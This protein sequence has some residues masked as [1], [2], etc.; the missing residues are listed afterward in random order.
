MRS[1]KCKMINLNVIS[2]LRAMVCSLQSKSTV[3]GI[4]DVKSLILSAKRVVS[5]I[6]D[7]RC[8]VW[9][10]IRKN[11]NWNL[12]W[13]TQRTYYR[14]L[15]CTSFMKLSVS[16]DAWSALLI[17]QCKDKYTIVQGYICT[18]RFLNIL[19]SDQVL[20]EVC[21][22]KREVGVQVIRHQARLTKQ[23]ALSA[24]SAADPTWPT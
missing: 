3:G 21:F 2:R 14:G 7:F 24:H 5:L 4:L 22:F 15:E 20:V 1:Q 8:H 6:A 10:N 17:Q 13:V 16:R 23:G 12:L 18:A 9:V 19:D 11:V